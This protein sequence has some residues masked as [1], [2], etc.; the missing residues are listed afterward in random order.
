MMDI[1]S[2][3]PCGVCIPAGNMALLTNTIGELQKD[4]SKIE[5]LG[6]SG[7]ERVLNHY[8]IERIAQQYRKV[9]DEASK[10]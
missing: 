7:I 8:T 3:N 9:W 6:R 10:K 2:S 5:A 1:H 4:Q